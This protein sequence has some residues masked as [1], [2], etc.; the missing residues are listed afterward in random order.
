MSFL[1][2]KDPEERDAIIEDYLAL[3]KRLK[4]RNFEERGYL[5]DRQSDLQE[6][7][8]PVVASNEK[9]TQDIIK[10][11]APITEGLQEINRNIE[12]KK[13]ALRPK[14]GSKRRLVS[15]YGPHAETFL[16][17]YLDDTVDK[18]FGIRYE[19]GNMI[20]DEVIKIRGDNIEMEGEVYMGTPGLCALIIERNPKEYLFEDY[21]RYN[22]VLY[23]TNVLYLDY[24]PRSSYPRVTEQKMD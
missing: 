3:K 12:M 22:E 15:G 20:G 18:T 24:N 17:K 11:L 14:I 19:S 5:M 10:D 21:E 13:E 7:F 6:T 16:Q 8:E 1:S 23:E 9:M 4:D 2:I